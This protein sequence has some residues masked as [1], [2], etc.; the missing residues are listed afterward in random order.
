MALGP[1][2]P[3][4]VDPVGNDLA[5]FG[6]LGQEGLSMQSSIASVASMAG[7]G[8]P[9]IGGLAGIGGNPATQS[10]LAGSMKQLLEM[11][12]SIWSQMLSSR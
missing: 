7:G 9:G 1:I 10:L 6:L 12:N 11:L 5:S 2:M 4:G 3:I 8:L